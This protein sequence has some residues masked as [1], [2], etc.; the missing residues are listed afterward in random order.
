MAST[1][2]FAIVWS[3]LRLTAT[4]LGTAQ[5]CQ[6]EGCEGHRRHP[7]TA[8]VDLVWPQRGAVRGGAPADGELHLPDRRVFPP[9]QRLQQIFS[10]G[11]SS[12]ATTR[13]VERLPLDR[14]DVE[15][16]PLGSRR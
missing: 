14:P 16:Q 2:G 10:A 15:R 9:D 4:T 1:F 13:A 3:G 8:A 6:R 5:P 12:G 11:V 7:P